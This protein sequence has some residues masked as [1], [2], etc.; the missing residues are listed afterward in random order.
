MKTLC[1]S[2]VMSLGLFVAIGFAQLASAQEAEFGA[3]IAADE[4]AAESGER[5]EQTESL[6]TNAEETYKDVEKTLGF[7]PD[8]IKSYPKVGVTGAWIKMK[9]LEMGE[10]SIDAKNKELI[11][12]SVAAQVPCEYCV[13]FHTAA[14]KAHGAS[15]EEVKEAVALAGGVREWSSVLNGQRLDKKKFEAD[16]DKIIKNMAKSKKMAE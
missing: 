16:V 8:F 15:E 13:I 6:P 3:Q 7:V 9:Q 14:A 5:Q 4:M 12:L 2:I 10:S 11:S 1:S